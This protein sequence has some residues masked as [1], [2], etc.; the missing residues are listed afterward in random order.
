MILIKVFASFLI[1]YFL[2]CL[3]LYYFQEKQI[4]FP[5]SKSNVVEDI[6]T[7]NKISLEV[8]SVVINGIYSGRLVKNQSVIVYFGGNAEDVFYNYSDFT[9]ELNSQFVA[10]NYRGFAGNAGDPTIAD[11]L[12][13][14]EKILTKLI[15]EFSLDRKNIFLMGRS[16]GAGIAVQ[17]AKDGRYAGMILISPFDSMVNIAK[18]YFKWLPVSIMLKH[19]LD[20]LSI[21]KKS[22]MPVLILAAQ[23]DQIIPISYS[24]ALFDAWLTKNKTI[25]IINNTDHNNIQSGEHYYYAINKFV[26]NNKPID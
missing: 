4:F 19:P 7:K 22:S 1:A 15:N 21:A 17:V 3:Y 18:R 11:I 10:F 8:N 6:P 26:D 20:S 14:M 13:D 24:Q 12:L 16:L 25:N 9:N 5:P 23:H 2:I